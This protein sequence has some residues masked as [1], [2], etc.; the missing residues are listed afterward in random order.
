MLTETTTFNSIDQNEETKPMLKKDNEK[1]NLNA[2]TAVA[3]ASEE[4]TSKLEMS[5][6]V[7]AEGGNSIFEKP[8]SHTLDTNSS[9]SGISD[10]DGPKPEA[11]VSQTP[12]KTILNSGPC[13]LLTPESNGKAV[14]GMVYA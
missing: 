1:D 12:Y 11:I 14:T 13:L 5:A 10:V 4:A 9:N 8:A 6:V 7:L 2:E 3:Q